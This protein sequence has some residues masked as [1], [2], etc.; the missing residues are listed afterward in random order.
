MDGSS[1]SIKFKTN[2]GK[3]EFAKILQIK[4]AVKIMLGYTKILVEHINSRKQVRENAY[5]LIPISYQSS[6]HTFIQL[7]I[8]S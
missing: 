6:S 7:E 8:Y 3:K 5:V 2:S 1:C 4:V